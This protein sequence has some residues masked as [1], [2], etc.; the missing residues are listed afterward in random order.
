MSE[1]D[2]AVEAR[3]MP[4]MLTIAETADVLRI[5]ALWPISSPSSTWPATRPGFP[6]SG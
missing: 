5:V 6:S 3:R 1:G 4:E 2:D